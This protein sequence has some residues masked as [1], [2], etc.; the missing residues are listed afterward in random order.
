MTEPSSGESVTVPSG[1]VDAELRPGRPATV[2][3]GNVDAV[4]SR[5]GSVFEPIGSEMSESDR[6]VQRA[7]EYA[8]KNLTVLDTR[9]RNL[10]EQYLEGQTANRPCSPP[11]E[12]SMIETTLSL[13]DPE[14]TPPDTPPK[15]FPGMTK[16]VVLP[17]A[18]TRRGPRFSKEL[19]DAQRRVQL[20]GYTG[21][22]ATFH[23]WSTCVKEVLQFKQLPAKMAAQAVRMALREEAMSLIS[24]RD[25]DCRYSVEKILRTLQREYCPAV[26]AA[27]LQKA[28][29]IRPKPNRS[30]LAYLFEVEDVI[31]NA[32][33]EGTPQEIKSVGKGLWTARDQ[34]LLAITITRIPRV[35]RDKIPAPSDMRDYA[36]FRQ[37]VA[38][39]E[40]LMGVIRDNDPRAR[41][42]SVMTP[43]EPLDEDKPIRMVQV[44]VINAQDKAE[45]MTA[46]REALRENVATAVWE[47]LVEF[48]TLL[49]EQDRLLAER[50][51]QYRSRE[52]ASSVGCFH[53]GKSTHYI[54]E[55]PTRRRRYGAFPV[56]KASQTAWG[57]Y[58][59]A[60]RMARE[61]CLQIVPEGETIRN[62]SKRNSSTKPRKVKPK[63]RHISKEMADAKAEPQKC[64]PS[65]AP[66]RGTPDEVSPKDAVVEVLS[67]PPVKIHYVGLRYKDNL[68]Q[69]ELWKSHRVEKSSKID[70]RTKA[71]T[72]ARTAPSSRPRTSATL[73]GTGRPDL[74][75]TEQLTSSGSSE[76]EDSLIGSPGLMQRRTKVPIGNAT[77]AATSPK[78]LQQVETGT[79]EIRR[80]RSQRYDLNQWRQR[81]VRAR[82]KPAGRNAQLAPY[83]KGFLSRFLRTL[84]Y[85]N[86]IT[87][88]LPVAVAT[89]PLRPL[90][91]PS[92]K[93]IL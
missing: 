28:R 55:C 83:A 62:P 93:P 36:E 87:G 40:G 20:P 49:E 74:E 73:S 56:A 27:A 15:I 24:R 19:E 44:N 46:S 45:V 38:A 48:V 31:D 12:L 64:R 66:G 53:C 54:Q 35:L 81:L 75:T 67:P 71:R 33:P 13:T 70:A 26:T 84:F 91:A 17:K 80:P 25:P 88:A 78:E 6:S 37:I 58:E 47:Q 85:A 68:L 23:D 61:D 59:R 4:S 3:S 16:E 51:D 50:L 21:D 52:V 79:P 65:D 42:R 8:R 76:S 2:P 41:V 72:G 90:E 34:T 22:P 18:R 32:F 63:R 1:N 14:L 29:S 7:L 43:F 5:D 82:P 10:E 39:E 86:V 57:M 77:I 89:Y 11:L 30:F 69:K 9:V 92:Q 60:K